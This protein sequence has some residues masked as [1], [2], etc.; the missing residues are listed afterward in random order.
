MTSLTGGCI[1]RA[2]VDC[3]FRIGGRP[4][5]RLAGNVHPDVRATW[6]ASFNTAND[7]TFRHE[8]MGDIYVQIARDSNRTASEADANKTKMSGHVSAVG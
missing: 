2:L 6:A 1:W 5:A 8:V 7:R 3:G 4:M